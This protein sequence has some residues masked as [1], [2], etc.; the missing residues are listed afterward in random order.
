MSPDEREVRHIGKK[1]F[2]P[3]HREVLTARPDIGKVTINQTISEKD[4]VQH[5]IIPKIGDPPSMAERK[6]MYPP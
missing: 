5:H 2:S 6:D 3:D 4:R 1:A